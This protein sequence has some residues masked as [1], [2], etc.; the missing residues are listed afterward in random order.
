MSAT[1]LPARALI[2]AVRFYQ[3]FIS[4]ALPPTCR[5]YPSCSAYALEAVQVHGAAKG[6]WLAVRRLLR[7][8]PW[9][10]GGVDPVPP[11]TPAPN[12]DPHDDS[13][14]K[15]EEQAPC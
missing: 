14:E 13:A 11:R 10:P 15:R 6:T 12:A 4:P 2:G 5:F 8:H 7:C 9:H 1:S 3:R